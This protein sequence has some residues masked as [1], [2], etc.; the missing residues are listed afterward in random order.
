VASSNGTNGHRP[1]V[2]EKV[3]EIGN[4]IWGSQVVNSIFRPGSVFRKGYTD[5]CVIV[6]T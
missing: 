1:K 5:S 2:L 4:N 3:G 6:P